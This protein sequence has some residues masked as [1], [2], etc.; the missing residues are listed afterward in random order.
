ME[1]PEHASEFLLCI[2]RG[3]DVASPELTRCSPGPRDTD[4]SLLSP[5]PLL[6]T[7]QP[8]WLVELSCTEAV[9]VQEF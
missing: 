8:P 4:P 3:L 6:R 5:G 1:R 9:H 2:K 7:P